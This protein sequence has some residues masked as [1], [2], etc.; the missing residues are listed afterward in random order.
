MISENAGQSLHDKATRGEI[1]TDN[2][3]ILLSDWYESQDEIEVEMLGLARAVPEN[4]TQFLQIRIKTGLE[5]LMSLTQQIQLII[6]ENE[7]L[8]REI[9]L[10]QSQ[11][12]RRAA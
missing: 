5:K 1:L 8:K 12:T 2:E 11:L 7:A 9:S 10:L 6:T 4:L 3:Q